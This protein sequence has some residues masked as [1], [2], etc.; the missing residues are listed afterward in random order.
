MDQMKKWAV[1]ADSI[2]ASAWNITE[3]WLTDVKDDLC[4]SHNITPITNEELIGAIPTLIGGISSNISRADILDSFETDSE[5]YQ[6]ASEFGKRRLEIGF[7]IED[8]I[9]QCATLRDVLYNH[10]ASIDD[11]SADEIIACNKNL[12]PAMDM[13]QK[14]M[15]KGFYGSAQIENYEQAVKDKLT[16]VYNADAIE[17]MLESEMCRSKRY[18]KAFSIAFI[19]IDDFKHLDPKGGTAEQD[20]ILKDVASQLV[21]FI[22]LTDSAARGNLGEFTILLPETDIDEAK[23]AVD[24]VR[25]S[26]KQDSVRKNDPITLSG[27]IVEYPS[28]GASLAELIKKGRLALKRANDDGGNTTKL[29][30]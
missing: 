26:I 24:R 14:A 20:R 11:L 7:Q 2:K 27:G 29:S 25:R 28:G 15:I 30:S 16:N 21:R 12:G 1:V 22:R 8:V 3:D 9:Q 5:L 23:K 13:I 6:I 10:I 19:G 4:I 18:R 17:K